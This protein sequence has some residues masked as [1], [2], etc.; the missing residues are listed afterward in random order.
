M[1]YFLLTVSNMNQITSCFISENK[2]GQWTY[3]PMNVL[4][5]LRST[6]T[7]YHNSLYAYCVKE[8]RP[9][10]SNVII[11][12][13]S[14]DIQHW[15]RTNHWR[16]VYIGL[17]TET[18]SMFAC[19]TDWVAHL[20]KSWTLHIQCGTNHIMVKQQT[21]KQHIGI[22]ELRCSV[23]GWASDSTAW[24]FIIRHTS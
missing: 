15:N 6:A 8:T 21:N 7:C 1:V 5:A 14:C 23:S 20:E 2:S 3:H 24:T 9:L 10:T 19:I 11:R 13:R 18:L 22:Q 4:M 17:N 12:W 16:T